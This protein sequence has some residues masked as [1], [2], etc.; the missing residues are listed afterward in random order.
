MFKKLFILMLAMG[1]I[2]FQS[3]GGDDETVAGSGDCTG[4]VDCAGACDGSAVADGNG[5]CCESG[6]LDCANVCDGSAVE[7]ACGTCGGDGSGCVCS[8]DVFDGN[9]VCCESGTLDCANVCDG[10]AVTDC[11]GECGGSAV[12]DGNGDCCL[13]GTL[14][15][16]DVCDGSA[17]EDVCGVCEGGGSLDNCGTCDADTSND[18]NLCDF[19]PANSIHISPTGQLWYNSSDAIAGF[20]FTLQGS[21][22]N[23]DTYSILGNDV[24]A[25]LMPT[26]GVPSGIVLGISLTGESIPPGCGAGYQFDIADPS[27]ITGLGAAGT[28]FIV[29]STTGTD[30]GFTYYTGG[31]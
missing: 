5:D 25:G 4:T 29:S 14:D 18:C 16:A 8:S 19:L 13:S 28:E 6:T 12:A 20:Q 30:L 22:F 23:S 24:P 1:L 11:N 26:I 21:S 2:V 15:C 9:G 7:D 27:A 10:S 3:C 31:E 17:V